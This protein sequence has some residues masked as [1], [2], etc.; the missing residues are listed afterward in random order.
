MDKILKVDDPVGAIGV[1]GIC[2]ATG[3]L[4]VGLFA[5]DG[6]LFYGGGFTLF[7]V[8][9]IGVLAVAAWTVATMSILFLVIKK[10][11]GL[12]VSAEEE[13]DGLDLHEHGLVS[14]YADF[15][16]KPNLKDVI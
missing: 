10:T 5:T 4:L 6:G 3:T 16:I 7:G 9:L 11:I 8:Q 12:R 2:G 15:E 14:S 1:H 13:I